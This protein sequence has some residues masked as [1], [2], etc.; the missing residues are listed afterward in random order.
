M[1]TAP[2]TMMSKPKTRF[3]GLAP[4]ADH[5]SKISKAVWLYTYK[6]LIGTFTQSSLAR[7]TGKQ[8]NLGMFVQKLCGMNGDRAA[9]EK[10]TAAYMGEWKKETITQDLREEALHEKNFSEVLGLLQEWNHKKINDTRGM[11]AWNNLPVEE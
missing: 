3:A 2:P 5:S 7:R 4:T 10:K 8:L 11:E 1:D 9:N 6:E